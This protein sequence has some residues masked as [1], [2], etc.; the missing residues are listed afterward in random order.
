MTRLT[1]NKVDNMMCELN[2]KTDSNS[3]KLNEND[4]H[5][6]AD[7]INSEYVDHANLILLG[8]Y[9]ALTIRNPKTRK[10]I[11]TFGVN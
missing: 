3:C 8:D 10:E 11:I 2:I 9:R 7:R 5:R 6:L 1:F 4:A